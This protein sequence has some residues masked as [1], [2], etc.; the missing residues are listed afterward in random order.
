MTRPKLPNRPPPVP[1]GR[2]RHTVWFLAAFYADAVAVGVHS[3]RP[4]DPS[5]L[6]LVGPVALALCLGWWA[7][8]DARRRRH[9]IPAS[10]RVWF[11]VFAG[12]VVP[13]YVVYSRGWR[14]AGWVALH[15]ALWYAVANVVMYGGWLLI[16][17][18]AGL[19]ALGL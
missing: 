2:P 12:I 11:F 4:S 8:V 14:G 3:I 9:P 7:V 16:H 15:G 17:G 18:E 5:P 19:R 6:D 10:S 13:G 1:P